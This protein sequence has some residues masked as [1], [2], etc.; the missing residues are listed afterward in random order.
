MDDSIGVTLMNRRRIEGEVSTL[1]ARHCRQTGRERLSDRS[2]KGNE[3]G[4]DAHSVAVNALNGPAIH[5]RQPM[6]FN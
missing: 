4:V 2:S 1:L 6:M 3:M 5:R